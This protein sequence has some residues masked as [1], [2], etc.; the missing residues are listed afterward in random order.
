MEL[1]K[2]EAYKDSKGNLYATEEEAKKAILTEF[3]LDGTKDKVTE[4]GNYMFSL[5]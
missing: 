1:E 5:P 2:V 4:G 3:I